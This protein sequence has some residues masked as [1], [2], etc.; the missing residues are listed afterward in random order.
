MSKKSHDFEH[1]RIME[2]VVWGSRAV[3]APR[4]FQQRG[5]SCGNEF[6]AVGKCLGSHSKFWSLTCAFNQS[7]LSYK[8]LGGFCFKTWSNRFQSINLHTRYFLGRYKKCGCL[9]GN[10]FCYIFGWCNHLLNGSSEIMMQSMLTLPSW[11]IYG[12]RGRDIM[13][14]HWGREKAP[15]FMHFGIAKPFPFR[16]QNHEMWK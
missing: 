11:L 6:Q 1:R 4:P 7:T 10:Y 12:T 3:S 16:A 9:K 13:L 2:R 8:Y 14:F 15:S 5:H